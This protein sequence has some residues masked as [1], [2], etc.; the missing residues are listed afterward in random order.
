MSIR[1]EIARR[2]DA[3]TGTAKRILGRATG[4]RRRNAEGHFDQAKGKMRRAA[5]RTKKAFKR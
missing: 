5:A 1:K 4:S 2:A 3:A